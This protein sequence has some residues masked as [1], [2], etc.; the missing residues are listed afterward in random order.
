MQMPWTIAIAVLSLTTYAVGLV[1]ISGLG[2]GIV[3]C[4]V[5]DMVVEANGETPC[6]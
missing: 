3:I 4:T 6:R 5:L 1:W 2:A